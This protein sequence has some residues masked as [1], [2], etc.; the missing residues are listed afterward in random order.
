MIAR[1]VHARSPPV[2]M[3]DWPQRELTITHSV[4]APQLRGGMATT[5]P[6]VPGSFMYVCRD[7]VKS[8]VEQQFDAEEF[9]EGAADAFTV[10]AR[11]EEATSCWSCA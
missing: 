10:G 4:P 7:F 11:N 1:S 6:L 3:H 2:C 5:R 9:L 8:K